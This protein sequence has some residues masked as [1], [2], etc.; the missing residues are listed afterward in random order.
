MGGVWRDNLGEKPIL[1]HSGMFP[2]RL[3]VASFWDQT[4]TLSKH[5]LTMALGD[6]SSLPTK[7]P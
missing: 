5:S 2:S 6:H 1:P 3:I 7:R 4:A